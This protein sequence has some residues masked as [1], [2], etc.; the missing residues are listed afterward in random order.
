MTLPRKVRPLPVKTAKD[1]AMSAEFRRLLQVC[2][3]RG[4]STLYLQHFFFVISLQSLFKMKLTQP[5]TF[6]SKNCAKVQGSCDNW[7][8]YNSFNSTPMPHLSPLVPRSRLYM[9]PSLPA[10]SQHQTLLLSFTCQTPRAFAISKALAFDSWRR[11]M[12][13]DVKSGGPLL[14]GRCQGPMYSPDWEFLG[15]TH[16]H[17]DSQCKSP[18][19]C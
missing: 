8:T 19:Y 1:S 2:A 15:V 13:S 4:A 10:S 14:V 12:G 3:P 7:N 5:N 18:L 9:G 11:E 16:G 17:T 6:Y